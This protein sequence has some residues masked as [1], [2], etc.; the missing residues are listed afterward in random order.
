[1]Q[2]VV[3]SEDN[4]E[5]IE[6]ATDEFRFFIG[7]VLKGE[8]PDIINRQQVFILNRKEAGQLKP[9]LDKWLGV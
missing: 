7:R 4:S 3:I 5:T 6:V 9:I 2:K 1:M 8:V